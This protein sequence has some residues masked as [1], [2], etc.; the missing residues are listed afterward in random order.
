MELLQGPEILK[1]RQSGSAKVASAILNADSRNN[2]NVDT[3]QE[4]Y[5][6]KL[7]SF[8][9]FPMRGFGRFDHALGIGVFSDQLEDALIRSANSRRGLMLNKGWRSPSLPD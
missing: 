4:L 5:K 7:H 9:V 6:S 2:P 3:K 8:A 1:K